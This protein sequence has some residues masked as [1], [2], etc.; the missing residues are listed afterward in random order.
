M[1]TIIVTVSGVVVAAASLLSMP[2]ASHAGDKASGKYATNVKYT[3]KVE[4]FGK[5]NSA[6][7]ENF[8]VSGKKVVAKSVR[9]GRQ[10]ADLDSDG[11]GDRVKLTAQFK[12]KLNQVATTAGKSKAKGTIID[13]GR[14]L[15]TD[16]SLTN[17]FKVKTGSFSFK[18]NRRGD[19]ALRGKVKAKG[20]TDPGN[21]SSLKTTLTVSLRGKG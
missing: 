3:T 6:F 21:G 9:T 2:T 14:N 13:K 10:S 1:K 18:S 12:L 17:K 16:T 5:Q 11:L 4:G 7:G 19:Q 15:D 20:N 8:K